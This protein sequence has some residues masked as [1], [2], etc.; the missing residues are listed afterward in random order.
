VDLAGLRFLLTT[1]GS[2]V[3]DELEL[4]GPIPVAG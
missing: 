4:I 2:A 1:F 3:N